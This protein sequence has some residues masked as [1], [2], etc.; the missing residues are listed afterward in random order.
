MIRKSI[1]L[2]AGMLVTVAV[3]AAG[4]QL[5]AD[6]PDS[7]TVRRGD[8][9]W[10]ISARFLS[11]PW[12]WPEIWQ[13]NPQVHNPHLIYP[14]DVLDLSFVNGGPSL[15]L[16]P[17]VH[18]EGEAIPALPLD[19]IKQFLKDSRVVDPSQVKDAPYVMGFEQ[20]DLTGT[21]GQNIYV[22]K[23]NAQPGQRW[24]I[25]RPT[26]VFRTY[27]GDEA[28]QSD[29]M[30]ANIADADV[31]TTDTPWMEEWATDLGN[32]TPNHTFRGKTLGMEVTVIGEAEVLRSGDPATLLLLNSTMEVRAGDRLMPVDDNPYDPYYYPHPPKTL[33]EN[34]RVIAF[35]QERLSQV[36]PY[37]VVVLSVG[38]KDGVD[39]GMTFSLWQP[40]E[41]VPDDVNHSSWMRDS[42]TW[43]KL[44]DEYV[45]HVMV[46]R[47]FDRVSYGL[48][49]DGLKPVQKGARIQLPE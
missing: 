44:P 36:G 27:G 40:G 11:K 2:L 38:S 15:R 39:N 19:A 29:E 17:S 20:A 41:K 5:R 22:R 46:F 48:V 12:L 49:M 26:H 23:L 31:A 3:Y 16:E 14:G 7:Y 45:G 34:G 6:H 30:A 35:A 24:A 1:G 8:T 9:L 13:A 33:P 25:V 32:V 42:H 37:D 21:A 4:A 47:T 43:V 10:S 28:K 18:H